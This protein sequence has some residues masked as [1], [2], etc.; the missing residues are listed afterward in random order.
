VDRDAKRMLKC[1]NWKSLAEDREAWRWRIEDAK[2]QVGCSAIE[3]EGGP[4]LYLDIQSV[5]DLPGGPVM[6]TAVAVDMIQYF[7]L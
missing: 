7:A 3:E 4:S 2:A 6:Q 1:G 5:V